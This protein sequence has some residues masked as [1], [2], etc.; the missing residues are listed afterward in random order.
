[1]SDADRKKWDQR[2][3]AGDYA[4]RIYP[5]EI[6]EQWLPKL[7]S[8]RALDVACGAG[9]NAMFL[10]SH[11]YQVDAVDISSEA[12]RRAADDARERELKVNWVVADLDDGQ[13]PGGDYDLVVVARYI[14]RDLIP[15][16]RDV[17]KPDGFVIYDHH[18]LTTRQV[19]GPSSSRFRVA[20]NELLALF[21]G[22]R[23]L[24]YDECVSADRDGRDMALAKLVACK[25]SPGF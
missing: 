18:L 23:I 6:L 21:A 1:M 5:S 19:D 13:L 14:D 8:G 20:P 25:G 22:F 3:R 12:L 10:A 2:Y 15:R 7:P 11:G 17:L 9:R 16:L 4:A 24:F